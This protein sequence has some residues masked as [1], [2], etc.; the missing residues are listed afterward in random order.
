MATKPAFSIFIKGVAIIDIKCY[1]FVSKIVDP[2][3][4]TLPVLVLPFGLSQA[5]FELICFTPVPDIDV[6]SIFAEGTIAIALLILLFQLNQL[7]ESDLQINSEIY[8]FVFLGF[9]LQFI[10]FWTTCFRS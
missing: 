10:A 6:Y 3:A 2:K 9:T 5:V 4:N 7:R 1:R 8:I